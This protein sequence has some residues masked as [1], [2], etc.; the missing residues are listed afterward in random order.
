MPTGKQRLPFQVFH[1]I[2]LP[3]LLLKYTEAESMA[4]SGINFLAYHLGTVLNAKNPKVY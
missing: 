4:A 1:A 2:F 3:Q